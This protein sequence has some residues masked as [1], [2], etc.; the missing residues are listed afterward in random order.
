[1]NMAVSISPHSVYLASLTALLEI[2]CL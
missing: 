1:M 2:F